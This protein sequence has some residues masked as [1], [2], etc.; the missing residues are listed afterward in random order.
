MV[1][2]LVC[3]LS[4]AFAAGCLSS[5]AVTCDDGRLCAAGT[6]CDDVHGKCLLPSQQHACDGKAAM[7]ACTVVTGDDGVCVDGWCLK[8]GC[9]DTIIE[10]GEQC[11]GES[12]ADGITCDAIGYYE[13]NGRL[14]CTPNCT[15]DPAGCTGHCGD[16]VVN[17]PEQCEPGVAIPPDKTCADAGYYGGGPLGCDPLHCTFNASACNGRCGDAIVNGPELC[18]GAWT[19]PQECVDFG[20]DAGT[21]SCLPGQCVP[22]LDACASIGWRL[23]PGAP[24]GKFAAIAGSSRDDVWLVG[25][26]LAYHWNG[27][28]WTAT[29]PDTGGFSI[30]AVWVAGP[31]DAWIVC[32]GGWISHWNGGNWSSETSPVPGVS[33]HGISG[34]A[35]GDV[36]AVGNAGTVIH[37]SATGWTSSAPLGANDL[38]SVFDRAGD[39]WM[40]GLGGAVYHNGALVDANTTA[41]LVAVWSSGPDDVWIAESGSQVDHWDGFRWSPMQTGLVDTLS[42]AGNDAHD[43]WA[44]DSTSLAHYDGVQWYQGIDLGIGKAISLWGAGNGEMWSAGVSAERY[45][46]RGLILRQAGVGDDQPRGLAGTAPDNLWISTQ[47]GALQ[48]FTGGGTWNTVGASTFTRGWG[49]GPSD[50]YF[51]DGTQIEH[52]DGLA[53]SIVAQTGGSQLSGVWGSSTDDVWAVGEITL[54]WSGGTKWVNAGGLGFVAE[55]VWGW[56]PDDVWAV[57]D[58]GGIAQYTS[59]AWSAVHGPTTAALHAVWGAAPDDVWAVGAAGTILHY[60]GNTWALVVAPSITSN[61]VE[62]TGNGPDDVWALADSGTLA[63]YDGV[64]W[65]PV[66]ANGLQESLGTTASI[67]SVPRHLFVTGPVLAQLD[68]VRPWTCRAHETAC[69]DG[70]DDDC[71]GLIDGADPDCAS[72]VRISQIAAGDEPIIEVV[73]RGAATAN[74]SGLEVRYRLGCDLFARGYVFPADAL[75]PKGE[76]F[77]AVLGTDLGERERFLDASFCKAP[78]QVNGW[79]ALCAGPCDTFMCSNVIDYVELGQ[80]P[81]PLACASFTPAPVDTTSATTGEGVTR[82]GFAGGRHGVAGEWTVA[83]V[84]RH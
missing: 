31:G 66:H 25:G 70:V 24:S 29:Q 48:Q 71:D 65:S 84:T 26:K 36:W 19:S 51:A 80:P 4:I 35:P 58:V 52:W 54:H 39:L 30:N 16:G 46:G 17:G 34:T 73:N 11:D 21:V 41:D 72:I 2:A 62:L 83:P 57:G 60:D 56:G 1:R 63:H 61:L 77:R 5:G 33:L 15:L 43:V 38:V 28:A 68:R 81:T 76:A 50:M 44:V 14:L 47:A 69:G 22:A 67:W 8:V 42:L 79:F 59:G 7:A 53:V 12:F 32:D 23:V 37:R 78:E 49:T 55:D 40:A 10:A 9:G 18:D 3:A 13:T 64:A 82:I 20:F 74:L 27:H 45:P 75:V 6:V